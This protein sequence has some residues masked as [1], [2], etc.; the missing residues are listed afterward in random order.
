MSESLDEVVF[1]RKYLIRESGGHID[2]QWIISRNHFFMQ[3]RIQERLKRKT[4]CPEIVDV[5]T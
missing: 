4:Y 2:E 5:H 1:E 3:M